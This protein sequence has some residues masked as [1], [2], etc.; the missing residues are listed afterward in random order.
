M[1]SILAVII[2]VLIGS[3]CVLFLLIATAV[4][5]ALIRLRDLNPSFRNL[6][7]DESVTVQFSDTE[8]NNLE[9]IIKLYSGIYRVNYAGIIALLLSLPLIAFRINIWVGIGIVATLIVGFS[10]FYKSLEFVI[11]YHIRNNN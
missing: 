2:D 1:N 4:S 6:L 8:R 5:I 7:N 11:F 3:A 10:Y 9:D